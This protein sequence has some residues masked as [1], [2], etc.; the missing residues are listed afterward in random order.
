[1]FLGDPEHNSIFLQTI[2]ILTITFTQR[3]MQRAIRVKKGE[4]RG[5]RGERRG[6]RGEEGGVERRWDGEE[7][8]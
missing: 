8:E 5:E 6:G 3:H 2:Y 7:M 4:G 1:M